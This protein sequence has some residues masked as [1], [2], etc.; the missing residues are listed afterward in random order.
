MNQWW[1]KD[2]G[3]VD[4]GRCAEEAPDSRSLKGQR[5][6]AWS[7]CGITAILSRAVAPMH[8][9]HRGAWRFAVMAPA[10]GWCAIFV[11]M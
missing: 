3:G 10:V 4:G 5:G 7:S 8:T 6:A 2:S 9:Q 1:R 11:D